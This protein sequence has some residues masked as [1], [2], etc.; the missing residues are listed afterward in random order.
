MIFDTVKVMGIVSESVKRVLVNGVAHDQFTFDSNAE[1]SWW[2][3][4]LLEFSA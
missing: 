1:V 2:M 3:L 4:S